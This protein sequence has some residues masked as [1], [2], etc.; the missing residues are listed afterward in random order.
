MEKILKN[1]PND[2]GY[3]WQQIF[4]IALRHK[5]E[6]VLAHIIALFA[7]ILSVPIPLLMPLLVDE[8]LLEQPAT[9]VNFV[10]GLFPTNWHGPILSI[11]F[12]ALV[13]LLLRVITLGLGVWQT[14][15]FT[16]IGKEVVY[17]IRKDL[18]VR[19]QRVSM[20]EYE[21]LGSGQVISHF[22][23][24]LDTLDQFIGV[25]ISKFLIAILTIISIAI[26][27]VWMHWQLA[28]FILLIN[29]LVIYSTISLGHKVKELKKKENN[30]YAIFQQT[31]TETLEAIQQIR[32]YNREKYY[33]GRVTDSAKKIKN[34]A[35]AYAWKSDAAGRLSFYVFLFG[36]EM[37]RA[38][39]ML[40]VV[41]SDLTIGQMFAVFG[42]LWFMLAPMQELINIQYSYNSAQ[43]ALQRVNKLFTLSFEPKYPHTYNPFDNQATTTIRLENICFSYNQ[44]D[45]ILDHIS[46]DIKAGEKVAFVGASGGGKTTLVQVVLGLYAPQSGTIYFNDIPVNQIGMDIV[47]EHVVTVL[48]HPDLFNDSLR[49][50]L[51]LGRKLSDE[52]L[53]QA[54]EIAQLSETVKNMED[55]LDTLLGQRGVRLSGGQ[56]QRVAVARMILNDP[57]VVILD[58]ATSALD[59]KTEGLL[60]TALNDFLK[61]KTTIIIAHRLSAVK[62]ADRVF[63]FEEGQIIEEGHHDH[64]IL[65]NGLYAKLYGSQIPK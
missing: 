56:R 34:H 45:Q 2:I 61:N 54:L 35:T 59:T 43:A 23:T 44:Q 18:I 62:Q 49:M 4:D 16:I 25:S 24:D 42:Y 65:E 15:Q 33:L 10:N 1:T 47:R 50:N 46:L 28:L 17:R 14:R 32:A 31:L 53:W 52:Q 36:F 21:T 11:T 3:N 30:A 41:F 38:I 48:Q 5:R 64:L 58:E 9:L 20:A 22:V 8:V 39:S 7:V 27:L 51:T 19:L 26:V 55:G 40:M 12:I 6:I 57:K 63:V 13:A 29:P 37:F 60:H